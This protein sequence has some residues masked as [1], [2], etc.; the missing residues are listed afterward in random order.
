MGVEFILY[1]E[2]THLRISKKALDPFSKLLLTISKEADDIK[3]L[4]E[5][6]DSLSIEELERTKAYFSGTGTRI[7][8][9]Q[10]RNVLIGSFMAGIMIFLLNMFQE[11]FFVAVIA[12]LFFLAC[13]TELFRTAL[14]FPIK[15]NLALAYSRGKY[16]RVVSLTDIILAER[17]AEVRKNSMKS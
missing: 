15:T 11:Y 1:L 8:F 5:T 12:L 14:T 2:V 10:L 9:Y 13:L 4:N 6:L 16:D 3:V 17:Y 7:S